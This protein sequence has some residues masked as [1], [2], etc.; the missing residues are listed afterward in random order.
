MVAKLFLASPKLFW[1]LL[2]TAYQLKHLNRET[3]MS[4]QEGNL[5]LTLFRF[6]SKITR[7]AAAILKMFVLGILSFSGKATTGVGI[8]K[9]LLREEVSIPVH[10]GGPGVGRDRWTLEK[11][12]C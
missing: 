6:M 10:R 12:L 1:Q 8:R 2:L 3:Q 5:E 7:K 9:P 11:C 4:T